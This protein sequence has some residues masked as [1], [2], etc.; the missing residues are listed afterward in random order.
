MKQLRLLYNIWVLGG[1]GVGVPVYL[2]T[3][4]IER[5]RMD[6]GDHDVKAFCSL[7]AQFTQQ[8][9]GVAGRGYNVDITSNLCVT[10]MKGWMGKMDVCWR[11]T[12]NLNECDRK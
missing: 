7:L 9:A 1:G 2:C 12:C 4:A 5:I 6:C 11:T 3:E 8:N 10:R